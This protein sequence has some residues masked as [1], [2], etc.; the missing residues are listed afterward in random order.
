MF[1]SVMLSCVLPCRCVEG[2]KLLTVCYLR[3][4]HS[5]SQTAKTPNRNWEPFERT[6]GPIDSDPDFMICS[7]MAPKMP[8]SFHFP[9]IVCRIK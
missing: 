4:L 8:H 9:F 7:R 5:N 3:Q 2:I 6:M 1:V